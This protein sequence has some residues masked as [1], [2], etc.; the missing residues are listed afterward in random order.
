[1][2]NH[3]QKYG[4]FERFSSVIAGFVDTLPM[5]Q[6]KYP[7]RKGYEGYSQDSLARDFLNYVP[8]DAHNAVTDVTVLH[9]LLLKANMTSQL[10]K[11]TA[12]SLTDFLK[13]RLAKETKQERTLSFGTLNTVRPGVKSKLI[14]LG[15]SLQDLI[16]MY[17]DG[18]SEGI[19]FFLS[20]SVNGKARVTGKP[21]DLTAIITELQLLQQIS[22]N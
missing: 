10:L 20:E 3:V 14:S 5:F 15:L 9:K 18:G 4:F 17:R 21:K 2:I 22:N 11:D 1:M 19:T 13:E 16:N 8:E 6:S 12:V 7:E